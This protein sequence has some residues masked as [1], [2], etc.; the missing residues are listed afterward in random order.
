MKMNYVMSNPVYAICEQQ[1]CRSACASAQSDH[2]LFFRCLDSIIPLTTSF[3][4]LNFK[5]L[6]IFCGCAVRFESTL[7]A[8][9]E[10]RFSRDEAQMIIILVIGQN[11]PRVTSWFV[12]P[13]ENSFPFFSF[14]EYYKHNDTEKSQHFQYCNRLYAPFHMRT[15]A[16]DAAF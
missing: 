8:N 15:G 7:V 9:P 12:F 10:D 5:S 1:R 16:E 3:Y 14:H 6:A 13:F 11:I 4:M 2:R